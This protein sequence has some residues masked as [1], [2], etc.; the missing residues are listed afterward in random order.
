VGLWSIGFGAAQGSGAEEGV[1][2]PLLGALAEAYNGSVYAIDAPT[3][4]AST[5]GSVFG[6][7]TSIACLDLTVDVVDPSGRRLTVRSRGG[8]TLTSRAK[9]HAEFRWRQLIVGDSRHPILELSPAAISSPPPVLAVTV[10]YKR[11]PAKPSTMEVRHHLLAAPQLRQPAVAHSMVAPVAAGRASA[12]YGAHVFRARAAHVLRRSTGSAADAK[13]F[14][15]LIAHSMT[16]QGSAVAKHPMVLRACA[17]LR[18][19]AD[20]IE[21]HDGGRTARAAIYSLSITNQNGSSADG[22]V[23]QSQDQRQSA[24]LF[25][26]T[27]SQA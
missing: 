21:R 20:A 15:D 7:L 24:D 22:H 8:G 19:A 26:A 5:I 3:Q 10:A 14:R 6:A 11:S 4:V 18:A 9:N 16:A 12:L 23:Y 27:L 25:A 1:D 17:D 2:W 13:V